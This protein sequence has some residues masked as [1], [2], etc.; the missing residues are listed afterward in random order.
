MID[1]LTNSSIRKVVAIGCEVIALT[2]VLLPKH[3]LLK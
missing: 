3:I 2:Q 1:L